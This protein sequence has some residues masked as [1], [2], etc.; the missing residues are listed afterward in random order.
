MILVAGATSQIGGSVV[1]RLPAANRE[2][3]ALVRRAEDAEA[4][5]ELGCDVVQGDVRDLEAVRRACE[6]T[7][8]A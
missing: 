3:R 4:F 6:G 8:A 2:V 7:E 1:E 5:R